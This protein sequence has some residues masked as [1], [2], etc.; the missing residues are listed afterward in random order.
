M[1]M[2]TS[3]GHATTSRGA[4]KEDLH[5]YHFCQDTFQERY[6]SVGAAKYSAMN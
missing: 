5:M 6:L 2:Q 3:C 4:A 1:Q